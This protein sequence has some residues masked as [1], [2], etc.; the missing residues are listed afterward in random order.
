MKIKDWRD[1]TEIKDNR[2]TSYGMDLRNSASFFR[3]KD[4]DLMPFWNGSCG[5]RA[6]ARVIKS[7][8][9]ELVHFRQKL[10]ANGLIGC[11]M[12]GQPE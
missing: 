7:V 11:P 4:R 5:R 6:R 10:T 3:F 2:D 12:T 9:Y 8:S 1:F